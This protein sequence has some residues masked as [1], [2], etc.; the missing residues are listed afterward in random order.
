[1]LQECL[2]NG[3]GRRRAHD[4]CM[5]QRTSEIKI[6]GA[7]FSYHDTASGKIDLF[8]GLDG[9]FLLHQIRA[10]DHHVGFGE[11]D[12]GPPDRVD[13]KESEVRLFGRDGID[14]LPR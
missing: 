12:A 3:W 4:V 9:G 8:V 14:R 1:M 10:F 13:G 7:P 2:H 5:L 11:C 6:V